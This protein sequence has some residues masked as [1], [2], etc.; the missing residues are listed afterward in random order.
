MA[1]RGIKLR[2]ID[3]GFDELLKK[4]EKDNL[5]VS[6]NTLRKKI[7]QFL[8]EYGVNEEYVRKGI[9]KSDYCFSIDWYQLLVLVM[10]EEVLN[11]T[12]KAQYPYKT[13]TAQEVFDYYDTMIKKIEAL[14]KH[15]RYHVYRQKDYYNHMHIYRNIK[16]IVEKVSQL[17]AA[18]MIITQ[19]DLGKMMG[20]TCMDID[21]MLKRIIKQHEINRDIGLGNQEVLRGMG[22]PEAEINRIRPYIDISSLEEILKELLSEYIVATKDI[23]EEKKDYDA[24]LLLNPSIDDENVESLRKKYLEEVATIKYRF[25]ENDYRR[26]VEMLYPEEQEHYKKVRE[27]ANERILEGEDLDYNRTLFLERIDDELQK[28]DEYRQYLLEKK[29]KISEAITQGAMKE[30]FYGKSKQEE[31]VEDSWFL[32][33][34]NNEKQYYQDIVESFVGRTIITAIEKKN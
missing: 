34:I 1:K 12:S 11:P 9:D 18:N 24:F 15:I 7:A 25:D 3:Y 2:E 5:K 26:Y 17:M 10:E 21:K 13:K 31:V 20:Q 22:V 28:I 6:D 30:I 4:M 33:E 19:Y 14:P 16:G 23:T 32:E 27:E 29:D 8:E